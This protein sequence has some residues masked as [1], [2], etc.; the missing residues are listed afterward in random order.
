MKYFIVEGI[1][2]TTE[3]MNDSLLK[4]H[5]AY[6]QKSMD[7]GNYLFSGLK[8]DQTGGIFIMKTTSKES[9]LSYLQDEPFYKAG[10]QTYTVK[11]FDAH[12]VYSDIKEWF[13]K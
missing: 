12:Y 10:I 8:R 4:K 5:M 3:G 1:I 9:L 2:K 7:E 6:T 13:S 11:E